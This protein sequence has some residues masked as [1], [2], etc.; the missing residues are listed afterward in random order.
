MLIIDV[1][2]YKLLSCFTESDPLDKNIYI[3]NRKNI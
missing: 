2:I 3:I 1:Y